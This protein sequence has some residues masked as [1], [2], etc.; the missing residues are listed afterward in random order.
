MIT[1]IVANRAMFAESDSVEPNNSRTVLKNAQVKVLVV[2]DEPLIRWAVTEMLG[3][4]GYRAVEAGD[5]RGA[6]AALSES[7]PFEIML[8]DVRLPDADGL[9]LFNRIRTLAPSA[10]VILMTA[11]AT[12]E[13]TDRAIALGA[14]AVVSKPFELTELADLV[15]RAR[16]A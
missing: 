9:T 7:A 5:A 12:R 3:D 13:L 2:D 15:S 10:R 1:E 14:F 4:L 6:I 16:A 11:D 8:L